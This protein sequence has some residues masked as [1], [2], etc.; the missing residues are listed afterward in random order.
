MESVRN[1][2]FQQ[3]AS[4]KLSK[5]EAK[6][7]LKELHLSNADEKDK[8]SRD[9]AIIGMAC[10]LPGAESLE[11]YWNN[12]VHGV[13]TMGEFPFNRRR[14]TD[15]FVSG[16]LEYRKGGY[17]DQVDRFDAP[18]FRISRR[19]AE[20]MDPMQRL[21]LETAWEA[22]EDSGVGSEKFRNT[23]TA[24]YVGQETNYNNE[25]RKLLAEEDEL[26]MTGSHTGI[27]ASRIQYLL[28][29]RG[30]S[31]V[32]DTACSSSLVALHLACQGLRNNE[33][34]YALVGGISAFFFPAGQTLVMESGA[35]EIRAFDK[36]ANGTCWSE[37]FGVIVLK[38]LDRAMRDRDHIH[39]IIKGSA[40]NNDGTS[41][42]ITAPN[43]DSQA[44]VITAAWEAA[45]IPPE[46]I[47]YIETHGTGTPLGDPIEIKG[48]TKAFRKYTNK[49][50]FCGIGS[51]KTNIGHAVATSGLASLM[52][53]VLAMQ[54]KKLP[55]SLSFV[56][57]NPHIHFADSP[58]YVNDRLRDW[59]TGGLPR[60]SG[61]SA[62]GFSGTNVHVV[63]EEAPDRIQSARM[64]HSSE[65]FTVSA[66]TETALRKLLNKYCEY[67][68]DHP[69]VSLTDFCYTVST[70]RRHYAI[71]L[72]FRVHTAQELLHKLQQAS[73]GRLEDIPESIPDS[74][75]GMHKLIFHKQ[76]KKNGELTEQD[77][78]RLS[79]DINGRLE[80]L[81][82][83]G[84]TDIAA[85]EI[86]R[87]YVSGADVNWSVIYKQ[88]EY[89]SL[90]VPIYP[91][92]R[93]RFWAN[94]EHL[95]Q[96]ME[97]A[98]LLVSAPLLDRYVSR[99][100]NE[101]IYE[102]DFNPDKHWVLSEHIIG[103]QAVLPGTAYVEMALEACEHYLGMP[104]S[105][106]EEIQFL[107]PFVVKNAETSVLRIAIREEEHRLYFTISSPQANRDEADWTVH[108]VGEFMRAARGE[109]TACD[110]TELIARCPRATTSEPESASSTGERSI[111]FGPRFQSIVSL[112]TGEQEALVEME[113]PSAYV[114]EAD[115]YRL[116]PALLDKA[117]GAV[118]DLLAGEGDLFLAFA[119][120]RLRIWGRL[121]EKVFSYVKKL[122]TSSR[123][124]MA[125][126]VTIM[127]QHGQVLAE[128]DKFTVKK[129]RGKS[130]DLLNQDE[131][132]PFFYEIGWR[133]I[134]APTSDRES[135]SA[136]VCVLKDPLAPADELL[137]ML[138]AGGYSVFQI[139][140]GD[141]Y[142]RLNDH[143]YV[144]SGSEE[145][146]VRLFSDDMRNV[147]FTR[148][149]HLTAWRQSQ[150]S[151]IDELQNLERRGVYDLY[152]LVRA[153]VK[154]KRRGNTE[155]VLV[156]DNAWEVTSRETAIKPVNAALFGLGKVV[157]SEYPDLSCRCID[158]DETAEAD[159]LW[160]ELTAEHAPY[161]V[162]YRE[163]K[164]YAEEI[165]PLFWEPEEQQELNLREDGVYVVS[166]GTGGIGLEIARWLA[167]RQS[168][169]LALLHR[170]SFPDRSRWE[171]LLAEGVD[172]KL[173]G[174]LRLIQAIEA[175]G[176]QVLLVRADVS[177]RKSLQTALD[178][179]RRLHG[180]IRGVVHSAG[181]A[182]DGFLI[183]KEE[184]T[185]RSVLAPK[186][187]GA[188]LL[189]E[190]TRE[191]SPDFFILFSSVTSFLAGAGQGDYTA[192]NAFLDA[193]AAYR[194]K[195]G[196]KTLT[197]NWPSWKETGMAYDYG[198]NQDGVF[199][200]LSTSDALKGFGTALQCPKSGVIIG[201]LN[202]DLIGNPEQ[203]PLLLSDEITIALKRR[204]LRTKREA[205]TSKNAHAVP[206]VLEGR[207]SGIY[208]EHELQLA[209]IWG[210][211]IG[212]DR[213]S[214]QDSFYDLGGDS[215]LAIKISNLI[216]K[217]MGQK[218][219]ISDLFEYLTILELAKAL[220]GV[221]PDSV[222]SEPSTASVSQQS[223]EERSYGLS[224]AQ[225][226]IWFLHKL[227]KE[228]SA[229]HLPLTF[230]TASSLNR[231][232][233]EDALQ[234][235]ARRHSSLRTVIREDE[236]Q[237]KQIVLSR[238][239]VQAEWQVLPPDT[240]G[241]DAYIGL[242]WEEHE[243]PF[244]FGERLWRVKVFERH[245]GQ[246]AICLTVHHL[247][248]DGWSMLVFKNELLQAYASLQAGE[249]PE[250]P[251]IQGD[252]LDWMIR[253]EERERSGEFLQMEN[254]WQEEL[255][256]PLSVL[257]LPIDYPRP[258][259]Q[260]YNGSYLL[261]E[262]DKERTARIKALAKRQKV[263]MHM[264]LLSAYF[265]FLNKLTQQE[266]I[267]VGYP[268][269]GRE[270]KEWEPVLGLF[271]NIV[272]MRL[273]FVEQRTFEELV[274]EVRQK[275]LQAYKYGSYPF[276]LLVSRLNAERDMS[277]S[278]I[279]Q[280]MFQ[281]Y[282]NYQQNERHSL[283]ELSFLCR[284][285]NDKLEVR[286]EYNTNLFARATVE[287]FA[288]QFRYVLGCLTADIT[289][290]IA[291]FSL[292]S[293]R[294]EA[295]LLEA[296]TNHQPE[297]LPDKTVVEWFQQGAASW[298]EAP[299]VICGE[300]RI[301]YRELEDRSNR[302]AKLL[303][304]IGV[305]A[306]EP[307]GL[308]V[309][310]GVDLITGMLGILKVG[311]AYV[312][313][314]PGYPAERI[315]YMLEHSEAR[316]LLTENAY[317]ERAA[318]F[319][320]PDGA[321][322]AIVDLTGQQSGQPEGLARIYH[323]G[324]V[325]SQSCESLPTQAGLHDLMYLIY[326]SGST[327]QPK[328]V[329]V[330]HANAANFLKWS[331]AHGR[332]GPS[333]LM[334]LLT[335]V[336]F[337][338]SVFEIFGALLSGACLCIATEE[339]LQNPAAML[340]FLNEKEITVWHSVPVLMRQLLIHLRQVPDQAKQL[341][342]ARI[343]RIMLGGEAWNAQVAGEIRSVFPQAEILNMYGP[344]E[345]T[346]WISCSRIGDELPE[347]GDL[348][349]GR[350]IAN[351][352]MLILDGRGRLCPVGV[353]GEI[354]IAGAN[355]TQGY[356]KDAQKTE[357]AYGRFEP[358]GERIYKTGD[359]GMYSPT[360]EIR[361][362]G[363]EDGM[364][365]VR[366]YRIETGEIES[367]LL[368]SRTISEA[369]VIARPEADTHKLVCYY[370]SSIMQEAGE[371]RDR[372]RQ[373]LPAY[374]MPAHFVRLDELP[375]TAN[376][377]IDRKRLGQLPL[378]EPSPATLSGGAEPVTKTE[379]QIQEIWCGLLDVRH[380][381]VYDQFFEIGGN[382][383]LVS[384]MH[385]Q[386]EKL[387]PGCITVADIFSYP[388][389]SE[390]ADFI[391]K[392]DS[393][394]HSASPLQDASEIELEKEL[395]EMFEGIASGDISVE[396][397]VKRLI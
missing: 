361:F 233:F 33:F 388:T 356:Y 34:E 354:A 65:L 72:A 150:A 352:K 186:I 64:N 299:A 174:K 177:E 295:E 318:S 35:A 94:G 300:K 136:A 142:G 311:G 308:M 154:S 141:A 167:E 109:R 248:A 52:K 188:W 130:Q 85:E 101:S 205:A 47:T 195:E 117:T 378:Q 137:G 78:L 363:R 253:M 269:A 287:S 3:V 14:D 165:R 341:A 49:R 223:V 181:V 26:S 343:R 389:I 112:R 384:Q 395:Y 244:D 387:Y 90:R 132:A 305:H 168:I 288:R 326:T 120:S 172:A 11:T 22:M 84:W 224:N 92:D 147:P 241:R 298:P 375:K 204:D 37:G 239:N 364:V 284:E 391:R 82:T 291:A 283:Y 213:I 155:I 315:E 196:N 328:G 385:Y 338:I 246:S 149:I 394:G 41:N 63:L 55:K 329:A 79:G 43:A 220:G 187:E 128:I 252:Y 98:A 221:N 202:Y 330:S 173:A 212:V 126:Q 232:L 83:S 193:Y 59:D 278:P 249:V 24:V 93:L 42:G 30:P 207:P 27:I 321:L 230:E 382:S 91:F 145:D 353:P 25:Y 374:M 342:T 19:E 313:L 280:T 62:F 260:T 379:R 106:M 54:H 270:S 289:R 235:M 67:L 113:L 294:E 176:S 258:A 310:R 7:L 358:T 125:Y 183:R 216:E 160:L 255:R 169:K 381:D 75:Y 135:A 262:I 251:I 199:K 327:G 16:G 143:H 307:V 247:I 164:R 386:I 348:S 4:N 6:A 89:R 357:E 23:R 76:E 237:P 238:M 217:R 301:S 226:R 257:E 340:A 256:K 140:L 267:V 349:I 31:L 53:V 184:E 61:V 285:S 81:L 214:L 259:M 103:G 51:V 146:Y 206:V 152:R 162:A 390:L 20:T 250:L 48:L 157:G 231:Q 39:A 9:I 124:F 189:D 383:F 345:T 277:R 21:F 115:V 314:D 191:E 359:I 32:L 236:G 304:E 179:V 209:S 227:D 28:N 268:I 218:I 99:T 306:N 334:A 303:C 350:P 170:S 80:S 118:S 376:G 57:P 100:A 317:M 105:G 71:R 108:A 192:A 1:Y 197:I 360:G 210:E 58:V 119:Y 371:L 347:R 68:R 158:L 40:M 10:K 123:E 133:E 46:S 335:S 292:H 2:I 8:P 74:F 15:P 151:D 397:A 242:L 355:V 13:R 36:G 362:L 111:V 351:N 366:G 272:C 286:L 73:A 296:Y 161:A 38:P 60:R 87:A 380:V 275:S 211:V 77:V 95:L 159:K 377:K 116:H 153:L 271:M 393:I 273:S 339:H 290:P 274:D 365:K 309:G 293:E 222:P 148:L 324:D 228:L 171:S 276:D 114:S 215:L 245:D 5:E 29:M 316:V 200:A 180:P 185:F 265:L 279:F 182:G 320:K 69:D 229:Y 234:L 332:L 131:R 322:S 344:T 70:G 97:T 156:A 18:F 263:S 333:D 12:L 203:S 66:R 370:A 282:E 225:K 372:L 396:D 134:A 346:I 17:I 373:S 190:L 122:D 44:E 240:N 102:T 323:S 166:G 297:G 194:M 107:A 325:E 121:P 392:T 319:V 261:F 367:I 163:G 96:Q 175:A 312:P 201:E 88:N 302:I 138:Q 369:A 219:D 198:V 331:I 281:F 264:L 129:L 127:D 208:S 110:L 56:E 336:S 178:E 50:Q 243:R 104:P 139:D 368:R 254:Y 86:G 144:V 266:D 337:D 45:G